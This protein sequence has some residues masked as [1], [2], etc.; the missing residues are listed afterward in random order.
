MDEPARHIACRYAC[1]VCAIAAVLAMPA[2]M[3][4]AL[5]LLPHHV[6]SAE[7]AHA[8]LSLALAATIVVVPMLVRA[9]FA[10]DAQ[11]GQRLP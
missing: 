2:V 3:Q 6:P 1:T 10:C 11:P 7:E 4:A 9:L 8:A 5:L